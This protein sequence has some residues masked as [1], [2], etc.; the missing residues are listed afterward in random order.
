MI[1]KEKAKADTR[2]ILM[3][4][5]S[6]KD[7]PFGTRHDTLVWAMEQI[8]AVWTEGRPADFGAA[9]EGI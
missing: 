8:E 2:E 7:E 1:D 4:V 9:P 5:R 6:S 3:V